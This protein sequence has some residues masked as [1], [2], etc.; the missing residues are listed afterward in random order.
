ML[1]HVSGTSGLKI[2]QPR[3]SSHGKP[4]VY[5]V[6]NFVTG[7]IFGAKHDDFDFMI[8]EDEADKP[9]IYECYAG[10]FDE[11]FKGK[12]CSVYEVSEDD[13]CRGATNW[14]PE[15]VCNHAVPV[16]WETVVPDLHGALLEE[17]ARGTLLIHRYEDALPY[18]KRISEHIVD[19]LIRFDALPRLEADER[20]QKHYK[21]MILALRSIMDGHL[22]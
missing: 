18:K 14:G 20:F 5:A 15:L 19:R 7:L 13:F 22:L 1:Y 10:A 17:E 3:L 2:L 12:R 4:Y 16:L 9:E 11:V 8:L 21:D 6:D